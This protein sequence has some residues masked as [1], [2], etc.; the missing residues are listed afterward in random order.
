M[1][2]D[3]L[4]SVLGDVDSVLQDAK[5]L[6][7]AGLEPPSI[8]R[9]FSKLKTIGLFDKIPIASEDALDIIEKRLGQP[10]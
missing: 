3:F 10:Q 5:L 4:A 8:S 7:S 2:V 1:R 9:L 6:E